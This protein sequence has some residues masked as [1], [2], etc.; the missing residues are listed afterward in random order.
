M[1][2]N[3]DRSKKYKVSSRTI[4]TKTFFAAAYI[5][6]CISSASAK[7]ERVSRTTV[8]LQPEKTVITW[9]LYDPMHT[10]RG[11]FKLKRGLVSVD[12]VDGSAEGLIEV[13][14][15][16]GESGNATRDRRMHASI[17]ESDRYPDISFRPTHVTGKIPPLADGVVKLDGILHLHGTD[18]PLQLVINFHQSTSGLVATTHFVIPYVDWGMKDPSTFIFRVG[19]TVEIN[20]E[21]VNYEIR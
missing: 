18:H 3:K 14:A 9:M 1:R 17:L 8:V 6:L 4:L 5:F 16:T 21:T 15:R 7:D 13:D 2:H 10:V 20:I 19:K 11:T 12:P